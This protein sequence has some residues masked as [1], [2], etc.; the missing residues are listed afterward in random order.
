MVT[1]T[2]F[3]LFG[4]TRFQQ[5]DR[6][7]RLP[8]RKLESL[9]AFLTLHP[10]QHLREKVATLFWG[11][12]Q[13]QEA[14]LSL[15]VALSHLRKALGDELLLADR[16][17]LA[18]N[19]A[20]PLWVDARELE[21][22]AN[23]V[24]R[25][26]L[27]QIE[28][29]LDLYQGALLT[30]FYD[31][32]IP[33]LRE[34]YQQRYLTT[35]LYV[36]QEWR[37]AGDYQR[38]IGWAHRLLTADR[39]HEQ[40]HQ[41]L[42]FCYAA[43]GDRSAALHQYDL[44]VRSLREELDVEPAPETTK[45]YRL[46][47][48]QGQRLAGATPSAASQ[49]TNLPVPLTRFVGRIQEVAAIKACFAP[50][51]ARDGAQMMSEA[52]RLVTLIGPGGSGKTRL[53]I[54]VGDALVARF[55]D[56]V[57][58]I[59][60]SGLNDA[61]LIVAIFAKVLGVQEN[62]QER[63][64]ATLL[65]SLRDQALLLVVDNCEHLLTAC[66][67]LIEQI[68]TACPDV[69]VLATSR[70]ALLLPGERRW[71]VP[72]LTLPPADSLLDALLRTEAIQLFVERAGAVRPDFRLTAENAPSVWQICQR[73][74]G[75]P[76]AIELAAIWVRSLACSEIALEIERSLDF[77][78]T[79]QRSLPERQRSI[80]A[81]FDY[82]WRL[83]SPEDQRIFARLSLFRG[84]FQRKAGE[85]VAGASL[86][87]LLALVD[88]SLLRHHTTPE[89][90]SRFTLHELL[91]QYAAEKLPHFAEAE[92]QRRHIH[93]YL[94]F[95]AQ[96]EQHLKGAL[97]R[98]ALDAIRAEEDNIRAAWLQ[99]IHLDEWPLILDA[100]R[101][102]VHYYDIRVEFE[103][104]ERLFAAA[105]TRLAAAPP[106]EP[107][108]ALAHA[109]LPGVLAWIDWQRL[110]NANGLML[111]EECMARL[112]TLV[113]T[114]PPTTAATLQLATWMPYPYFIRGA[115][116][117]TT[118][119]LAACLHDHTEA[120]AC[121]SAIGDWW[122][123]ATLLTS[124]VQFAVLVGYDHDAESRIQQSLTIS[125]QSGDLRSR[126]FALRTLGNKRFNEGLWTEAHAYLTESLDLFRQ[127]NAGR[128]IA[129][130][131]TLLSRTAI[132]LGALTQAESYSN[133][134]LALGR[135]DPYP[136]IVIQGRYQL[137]RIALL[138]GDLARAHSYAEQA[139]H[140]SRTAQATI[141]EVEAQ[142]LLSDVA[143]AQQVWPTA[144]QW[145]ESALAQSGAGGMPLVHL[146]AQQTLAGLLA[147]S[148]DPGDT[149]RAYTLY[150][151]ALAWTIA[152]NSTG[153]TIQL[154]LALLPLLVKTAAWHPVAT[155]AHWVAAQPQASPTQAQAAQTLLALARTQLAP[156]P[157][158]TPDGA[159][160][161]PLT[162]LLTLI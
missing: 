159:E 109:I 43:S 79:N 110:H 41:H 54:Q 96:Q 81:A 94:T 112:Q 67:E 106:V 123:V 88:K 72:A 89:G 100:T 82:S 125:A 18:L 113:T 42:I 28:A 111:A 51:S 14:R 115:L 58:W 60:L 105:Y 117:A 102:L 46:L 56:G 44:C 73:L 87:S 137:G 119:N 5:G 22:C 74:E 101:S 4:A 160:V 77:L 39:T 47:Q 162:H 155:I 33:P 150:R 62:Q 15:R 2:Q 143:A 138:R 135:V 52:A 107:A 140:E 144:R 27:V 23:Q 158:A 20:F 154:L 66:A 65:R 146:F 64:L 98:R 68:L 90:E 148:A 17:T 69:A 103:E 61:A 19:P 152:S 24:G 121:F 34:Y 35:G 70:E 149:E 53:A 147:T 122:G 32:W 55:P 126:A 10:G 97:I 118:G 83:L 45:L 120:L 49:L 57:W 40:I 31:A 136:L 139:L 86:A 128:N 131:L 134:L 104:G 132:E 142:L 151:A 50:T 36:V 3:T 6:L 16:L 84:G 1:N 48:Q 156:A 80:R 30:D 7:V 141:D 12:H 124:M 21:A 108:A 157:C 127:I 116:H 85:A 11:E 78:A 92:P 95:V 59:D 37:S 161:V 9:V 91:R 76:L 38:A 130:A 93:Y 75:I 13:E 8:T 71:L 129:S 153:R 26:P 25:L 114:W 145:A 99:A 63:L 133:E 29:G